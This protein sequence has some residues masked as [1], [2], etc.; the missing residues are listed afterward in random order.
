MEPIKPML[1]TA[2]HLPEDDRQYGFE[3][4]WD[5]LRAIVYICNH[6][7][8]VLSRNLL[9]ITRQYPELQPL[10]HACQVHSAVLDGEI[11]AFAQNGKPSFECLQNRMGLVSGKIIKNRSL[12]IPVTYIIFD[13]LA[14]GDRILIDESYAC[15]REILQKLNLQGPNWQTPPYTRGNGQALL[16]ASRRL[17]LEGIIAKRLTSIYTPGKRTGDWLKIKNQLRQEL[18]IG[19]WISGKGNRAGRIGALLV[20]VYD[21]SP[22][23]AAACGRQQCL[24]YSG[25]VGTGFTFA[26]LNKLEEYLQE[27]K[28]EENPFDSEI[29]VR[30]PHFVKPVLI[31]EFEFTGWTAN[32]T[33]RHPSFKGLRV[34]KDP[35]SV[36]REAY[37]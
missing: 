8:R 5:G 32:N 27:L 6:S 13:L 22:E 35:H 4:K 7:V 26:M 17:G 12:S 31:G 30:D 2:A 19:G 9:D 10:A 11:V 24:R 3:I 36:V 23:Q 1:A 18:V 14:I 33:L 25:R 29:P 15:R 34:D 16:A 28:F 37:Q 20:G 21:L